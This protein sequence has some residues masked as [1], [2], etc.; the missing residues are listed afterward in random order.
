MPEDEWLASVAETEARQAREWPLICA[1]CGI[2][3]RHRGDLFEGPS[4][5]RGHDGHEHRP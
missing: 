4:G 1:V 3:V 2:R 5:S